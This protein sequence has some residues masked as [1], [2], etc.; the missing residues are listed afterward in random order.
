MQIIKR[1]G[2]M[3]LW[4][5]LV[6]GTAVVTAAIKQRFADGPNR[7]FSGGELVSGELYEGAEPD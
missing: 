5:L 3:A 7:V 6:L 2:V 1:V 4:V